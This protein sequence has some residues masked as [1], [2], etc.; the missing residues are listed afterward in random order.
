ME[1]ALLAAAAA[2]SSS[3]LNVDSLIQSALAA[4]IPP[5]QVVQ[6]SLFFI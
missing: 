4:G 5:L 3:S 2:A 1:Q 6:V